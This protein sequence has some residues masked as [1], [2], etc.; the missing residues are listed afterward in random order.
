VKPERLD[1][2]TREAHRTEIHPDRDHPE[3]PPDVVHQLRQVYG[4]VGSRA[5]T[6][7]VFNPRTV[8]PAPRPAIVFLHGGCWWKGSPSQFHFFSGYLASR[9]GFCAMNVDY[10]YSQEAPFPAALQDA[11]CAVRWLRSQ[12]QAMNIDP[13]RIA[14]GGGS[15]GAHLASMMLATAGVPEYEGDGGNDGLGSQVN[16]GI[17]F[18]GEYDMWDLLRRGS[19]IEAMRQFIGGTPQEL[20][21]GYDEISSIERIHKDMPPT[22]L[23]H[24][25]ADIGVPCQ[26]S[27]DFHNKLKAVDVHSELEV[28]LDKAHA[29]FNFEPDRSLTLKR[30]ERFLVEQFHL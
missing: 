4:R 10:R 11:K 9:Y 30:I 19:L 6:A 20:P 17:L 12:A 25:T 24:G 23:L 3:V 15:A 2:A 7:D 8:R 14:V 22:L 16:L 1:A 29:W 21:R 5:L 18:N 28:Y 13:D 26:Q 27:I